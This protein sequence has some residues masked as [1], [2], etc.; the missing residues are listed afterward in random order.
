MSGLGITCIV[1]IGLCVVCIGIS[2]WM[3]W[4]DK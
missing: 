3:D 1:V 2:A 4:R